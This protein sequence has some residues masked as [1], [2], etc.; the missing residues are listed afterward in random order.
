MIKNSPP[1]TTP[2]THLISLRTWLLWVFVC[3]AEPVLYTIAKT[4]IG[5][6]VLASDPNA[7]LIWWSLMALILATLTGPFVLQWL[8]LRRIAPSLRLSL[9]FLSTILLASL[10]AGFRLKF[11][12]WA[13]TGTSFRIHSLSINSDS[14]ITLKE[15][16]SLPWSEYLFGTSLLAGIAALVPAVLLGKASGRPIYFFVIAAMLGSC[17]AGVVSFFYTLGFGFQDYYPLNGRS[18]MTRIEAL[19]LQGGI[20]AVWGASSGLILVYFFRRN[21]ESKNASTAVKSTPKLPVMVASTFLIA[22]LAPTFLYLT[23]NQGIKAG[24]PSIRKALSSLPNQEESKGESILIF[25]HNAGFSPPKFPVVRFAPDSKSF[26]A[27]DADRTLQRVDL[28]TGASLGSLGKQLGPYDRYDLDWSP[29]G[30]YLVLR[31]S[32]EEVKILN[33]HY[34]KQR[35]RFSLY[36]L[37]EYKLVGEYTHREDECFDSYG[38]T[39]LFDADGKSLWAIC[40]QFYTSPMDPEYIMALKFDVPTMKVLDVRRYGESASHGQ[41]KSLARFGDGIVYWQQG[42]GNTASIYFENLTHNQNMFKL[43]ELTQPNLAGSLTFQGGQADGGQFNLLFCGHSSGI[44]DAS[45][46]E[47]DASMV[48]SFCRT[49]VYDAQSGTLIKKIDVAKRDRVSTTAT[50]TNF[51][52]DFRVEASRQEI[53]KA[54]ELVVL[55]DKTGRERQRIAS[56]SQRPLGFSPDGRWLVTHASDQNTLRIYRV[57]TNRPSGSE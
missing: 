56:M 11:P 38:Q 5:K 7:T 51:Q 45:E 26:M 22:A 35:S 32:G 4:A 6:T 57:A 55:D 34:T 18:W 48:H 39:V 23:S 3:A 42:V 37:P 2:V 49:L 21:D 30:H 8:V 33:T 17:V 28:I 13:L 47:K 29:D 46:I 43:S 44:S 1:Q 27:L 54:G 20:G 10:S 24:F 40:A 36:A 16:I 52:Q 19:S 53:S 31:T 14:V 41:I 15:L 9:W 50:I 12:D 25:S